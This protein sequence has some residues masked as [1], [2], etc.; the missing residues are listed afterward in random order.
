ML[1]RFLSNETI[2][3]LHLVSA[4]R[5]EVLDRLGVDQRAGQERFHAADVDLKTAFDAIDDATGDRFISLE[6]RFDV[7]PDAHPS[8]FLAGESDV[9]G[10]ILEALDEDL[11]LVSPL[12]LDD[13]VKT[14]DFPDRQ[15]AFRF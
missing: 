14:G 10:G 6:G 5:V 13:S 7:V 15:E 8:R 2:L 12:D 1:L 9:A 3:N 4:Q 11:D